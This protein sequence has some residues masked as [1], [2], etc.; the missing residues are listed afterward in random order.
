MRCLFLWNNVT[1]VC[2][3]QCL[4]LGTLV[5]ASE[6]PTQS[7]ID[8]PPPMEPLGRRGGGTSYQGWGGP[9]HVNQNWGWEAPWGSGGFQKKCARSPRCPRRN[10]FANYLSTWSLL[11][12]IY[13]CAALQRWVCACPSLGWGPWSSLLFDSDP[14]VGLGRIILWGDTTFVKKEERSFCLAIPDLCFDSIRDPDLEC[15]LPWWTYWSYFP[16]TIPHR[17]DSNA[18]NPQYFF[19]GQLTPWN[20][21]GGIFC[22]LE[23]L[24]CREFHC[25]CVSWMSLVLVLRG[26]TYISIFL[27]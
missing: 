22:F 17:G 23:I 21:L 7:V 16:L 6:T 27:Q 13:L 19:S 15:A 9:Y 12:L 3:C 1:L 20:N 8:D 2:D 10:I 5:N 4:Y 11:C 14:V 18:I 26:Y 24:C 25:A